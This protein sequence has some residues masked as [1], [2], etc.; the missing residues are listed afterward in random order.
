MRSLYEKLI[1]L[2]VPVETVSMA[3]NSGHPEMLTATTNDY[4]VRI[5]S[6]STVDILILTTKE[7]HLKIP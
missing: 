3:K 6:K 7:I 4:E 1:G 5:N 2:P